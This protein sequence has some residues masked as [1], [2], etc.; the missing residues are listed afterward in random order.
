MVTERLNETH[1]MELPVAPI[2]FQEILEDI[3][4]LKS[5]KVPGDDRIDNVVAKALPNRAI[6]LEMC[7]HNHVAKTR[8]AI[9]QAFERV[10]HERLLAKIKMILNRA[11]LCEVLKNFL[12]ERT[13]RVVKEGAASLTKT[14]KAEEQHGTVDAR[15][16]FDS[17]IRS[18]KSK[19]VRVN[20]CVGSPELSGISVTGTSPRTATYHLL[21]MLSKIKRRTILVSS[22]ATLIY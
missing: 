12:T 2:T 17:H 15:L 1:Q 8:K 19:L 7:P 16:T 18:V 21:V 3:K 22:E 6:L 5:K 13:F 11:Q 9:S 20:F 14:I 10:W 4:K